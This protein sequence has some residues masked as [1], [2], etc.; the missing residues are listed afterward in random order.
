MRV[1]EAQ[2]KRSA[3]RLVCPGC[4]RK[5]VRG[6]VDGMSTWCEPCARRGKP[7]VVAMRFIPVR[8]RSVPMCEPCWGGGVGPGVGDPEPRQ[9]APPPPQPSRLPAA[10]PASQIEFR[11]EP[12][13]RPRTT[14]RPDYAAIQKDRDAGVP[15]SQ[16]V[17]KYNVSAASIYGNT[18]KPVA[19]VAPAKAAAIIT[20]L[21]TSSAN[22]V[23]SL[24]AD[25]KAK[26]EEIERAIESLEAVRHLLE[27]G[28]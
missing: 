24:I 22:S 28:A 23:D 1:D 14:E 9:P 13:G 25:L 17:Q 8:G 20:P 4:C 2:Q 18:R 26:K 6:R 5:A 10:I 27:Q 21:R 12:V 15:M 19:T 11:D 16:L 7:Q 3:A